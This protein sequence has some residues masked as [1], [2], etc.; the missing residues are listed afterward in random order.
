MKFQTFKRMEDD[1]KS[2]FKPTT[3]TG[4]INWPGRVSRYDLVY[5]TPPD[6]P[7][8]GMPIGNGEVGAL[9]WFEGSKI[10]MVVNKSDHIALALFAVGHQQRAMHGIAL[11]QVIGQFRFKL[12][13]VN[14]AI[15]PDHQVVT[16]EK[17]VNGRG[18]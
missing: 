2:A 13:P 9:C 18:V 8:H 3:G 14:R 1:M 16:M 6:D 4:E 10:M 11:P 15:L 5:L 12:A 7:L 17:T